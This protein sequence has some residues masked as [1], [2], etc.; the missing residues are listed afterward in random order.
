MQEMGSLRGEGIDSSF[1]IHCGA[2]LGCL[3]LEPTPELYVAHLVQI[4]GEVK[5]TLRHDGTLWL[6]IGDSYAGGGMGG[7]IDHKAATGVVGRAYN[8]YGLKPKDMVM[9]PFRL[10]LALQR[11]GWWM[12]SDIIWHK[13]NCMPSSVKDR[14]TTDF[15]HVFLLAKSKKYYYDA[16]AIREPHQPQSY[17]RYQHKESLGLPRVWT[18]A[19]GAG[20]PISGGKKVNYNLSSGGRNKRTVWTVNTKP[21]KDAHFATFPPKLIEPMVLA[22]SSDKACEHCGAAWTRVTETVEFGRADTGS[23]LEDGLHERSGARS[24][25]T[26][27]QA[28]RAAG[29]ESPPS[30]IT[31]GWQPS[32]DCPDNNGTSAS[33]VFDP[34]AGSGTVCA[35]AKKH[36]R[37]WVGIEANPEYCELAE[38]RIRIEQSQLKLDLRGEVR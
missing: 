36:G 14:P 37:R 29:L 23:V 24:L 22:G 5:R 15:E 16:D 17:Q 8:G 19:D 2:W 3:G 38:E 10:A 20:I 11:D 12:R 21:Y 7:H 4:F 31:T 32:C 26:K 9:I 13:P 1:C 35:E 33:I 25:A 27:R 30:P 34:F 28:Y 18:E 6:N